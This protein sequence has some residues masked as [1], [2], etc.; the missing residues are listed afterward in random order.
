[1]CDV[2]MYDVCINIC[3][4]D[5]CIYVCIYVV[6]IY[7]LYNPHILILKKDDI[8]MGHQIRYV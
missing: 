8:H 3:M 2:C 7:V 1:M 6:C 4:Y 5:V